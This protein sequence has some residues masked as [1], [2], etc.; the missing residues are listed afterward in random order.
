M[1]NHGAKLCARSYVDEERQHLAK[2]KQYV[3][4]LHKTS[5]KIAEVTGKNR[6]TDSHPSPKEAKS[7]SNHAHNSTMSEKTGKR[8]T[9][10]PK[11]VSI[12]RLEKLITS[13][14][15]GRS[16]HPHLCNL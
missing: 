4:M 9:G 3:K 10:I 12:V 15:R 14:P 1:C 2:T 8:R 7:G 13:G 11:K 6:Y 16:H 5:L